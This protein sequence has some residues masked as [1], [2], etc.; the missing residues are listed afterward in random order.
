M[1]QR[2][3]TL[4]LLWFA[5]AALLALLALL[6]SLRSTGGAAVDAALVIN[7]LLLP[8]PLLCVFMLRR[9]ADNSR[10]LIAST[11][12]ATEAK[13]RF[14]AQLSHE[15]RTPMNT[16]MGMTQL[17]LQTPLTAEQRD[18]LTKADAASRMLLGLVNDVLDVS[19]I[20][21]GHME[22][23]SLPLRLEDVVGQAIELVRPV[24]ANPDVALICDWAD[25]SL[26][27]A[28]GQLRGDA[29]R[30]QQVLVNLLS[31]ALKFTPAGEVLLRLAANPGDA[32]GRVPLSIT[33]QDSGIGMSAGQLEG[34]FSEFRQ[35]DASIPRRYGG[36]GLGLAIT[37]RLVELMGGTLDVQSQ[38]GRGSSFEIRL[39]LPLD[40]AGTP[41]PALQPVRLL[42]AK[43]RAES[44]EATLALLRHLGLGPGLGAS[45]DVAGTLA[46]L[47]EARQAGRPFDWLLLDWLLP[48]PGATAAELLAQLRR[49]YPALRIAVLSPPGVDEGPAQARG[50]GARALCPKPLL[51]QELRR[52]LSNARADRPAG[53][54]AQSLAGLRVLLVEDHPINQE[55]ALRLL[56]SRGAQVD[57][58]GN[59]QEGLDR[60]QARGPGAYD[61]VLMDLQMPVLDGLS[62]TRRLRALPE[63]D[64]LPVLAMTAHAL[65]EERAQC[66]AAGMQGHI[67]KPLD[68]GRLVRELQRYR[69]LPE[70]PESPVS[71]PQRLTLDVRLGLGRFDGQTALYRRTLQGF[72][73]QYAAGLGGWSDWLANGD[74]AELRRA[75]HTLQGLAATLGAQPLHQL[76]LALER[77]ASAAD[78]ASAGTQLGRVEAGLALLQ[79]EIQATLARPWDEPARRVAGPGDLDE[80]HQLLAQSDSRA[81]D[82]WQAHGAHSGLKPELQQRLDR[83]LAALD[84][85]A[86]ALALKSGA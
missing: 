40:P 31:N 76:A 86:A 4:G 27:G 2:T 83:A 77:S 17:A 1:H 56:S 24:H 20:E 73:D 7:A 5:S 36:T 84:F 70:P 23:E 12:A 60:L 39:A 47:A 82:W 30:L 21:A 68:V 15:I 61:L 50:F 55:I 48:G 22:I 32:D 59:G 62:A 10:T 43:A 72:A 19:K 51:P 33:V 58:A 52:L 75:A 64:T 74:W 29:L 37:R 6:W 34:L 71:S 18:L 14:L 25:A 35:G 11:Q 67:A 41:P 26:L 13:T 69:P 65:A 53:V 42:L 16:V 46:A 79:A 9:H 57:V 28:R 49:D 3:L 45:I 44:R 54:D 78:A 63:F 38:P 85:D 80:L 81:L 66:M 8:L